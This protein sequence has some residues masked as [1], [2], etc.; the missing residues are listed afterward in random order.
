MVIG[1]VII[2]SASKAQPPTT[3]GITSHLARR[4]TNENNENMPPSPLL[5]A[6]RVIITYLMVVCKVKVQNIQDIPPKI[7]V[8]E[9]TL[10]PTIALKTYN[11]EVPMSP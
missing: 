8:S 5:S 2:P 11:G 3:A 7:N 9:M 4:R 1:G 10:G 6:C